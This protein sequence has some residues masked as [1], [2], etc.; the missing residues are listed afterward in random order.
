[1]K[2]IG[3]FTL[4]LLTVFSLIIVSCSTTKPTETP[5]LQNTETAVVETEVKA[6]FTP[7]ATPPP[8]P[9][10]CTVAYDTDRDGNWEIYKTNPDG[11]GT[12]N[13][14]NNPG[15]DHAPAF[16]PDGDL[17]AF[18]S[19]RENG[20][21]P[22]KFIYVMNAD[23]SGVR[24]LTH[25]ENCDDPDW[26]YDGKMITYS[27]NGDI[28]II[29]ADGSGNSINLTKDSPEED[30][31]PRWSPDG[32]KIAWL[33]KNQWGRNVYVMDAD[34][35]NI[36][37][38][39]KNNQSFNISWTPDGRLFTGWIW[40][41]R[42]EFCHNCVSNIDGT[43]ITDAGGKGGIAL[44][45]PFWTIAGDRA[46][47]FQADLISGNDDIFVIGGSQPD[48]LDMGIG[49]INLTNNPAADR[50]PS[51]PIN[52]GNGW[53]VADEVK[54]QAN[55]SPAATTQ[56]NELENIVIGYAGD[57]PTQWQR[58]NN[59]EKACSEMGIQCMNGNI[60]DLLN[61]KVN[62]IVLNSSPEKIKDESSAIAEAIDK[63]IPVFVLDA[64]TDVDGVYSVLADPGEM[65][66]VTVNNL[67]KDSGNSGEFAYFDFSPTQWDAEIIQ[68][69]LEKE[70]PKIKVVTSD[71]ERYNFKNDKSLIYEL[72]D[73]YPTLKAVWTNDGNDNAIFGIVEHYSDPAKYPML[74][75]SANKD[76]F[77][78]WKDRLVDYPEFKCVSV[79]NPPG[80]AYDAV[81]AAYFLV[82]GETIDDSALTGEFGNAFWVD[83]PIITND[84]VHEEL[85]I[86]EYEPGDHVVDR[87]M[88]PEEIKDKW[89][90]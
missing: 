76:G 33:V 70:Y 72:L 14:T 17:I 81:Y 78:I 74:K 35:S 5:V 56:P 22:G 82:S 51:Y 19:N 20:D 77:Y 9:I 53:V 40:E 86:I 90:K 27:N 68:A 65:M 37:Q 75:C 31:A 26:S 54:V 44:Y 12:V 39:G 57:D 24:Q 55:T 18:V 11:T 6:T 87:L 16:S 3:L 67:F 1:M 80:I 69:I 29:K 49:S 61:Q 89:F 8:E 64:E 60:P 50:N 83:F 41:S 71:T 7:T 85:E 66:R 2:K 73:D 30:M 15:D 88:T 43:G 84:N 4:S 36:I 38:V 59:F 47:L 58:K 63:G 42:D 25:E 45:L 34:G 32:T 21:E 28:Y 10:V 46:E 23:G 79:S 52:C 62:A 48:T 13:L